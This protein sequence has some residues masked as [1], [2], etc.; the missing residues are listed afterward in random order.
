M[1]L[2]R[3]ESKSPSTWGNAGCTAG[4]FNCSFTI[5]GLSPSSAHVHLSYPSPS[6]SSPHRNDP[7]VLCSQ[8]HCSKH[9]PRTEASASAHRNAQSG[10]LPQTRGAEPAFRQ[11]PGD[12]CTTESRKH[13]RE[14]PRDPNPAHLLQAQRLGRLSPSSR[15]LFRSPA[16]APQ[17]HVWDPHPVL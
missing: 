5:K 6:S 10:A 16:A 1:E 2:L 4:C 11:D 14:L 12:L 13:S 15:K 8:P 17:P 9:G 3:R 7:I